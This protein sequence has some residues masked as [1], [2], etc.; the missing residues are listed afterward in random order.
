MNRFAETR[1]RANKQ[2]CLDYFFIF[3]ERHINHLVK[4]MLAFY[5]ESRP[6]QAKDN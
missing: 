5:H 1:I 3:G 6:H 4:E 2:G